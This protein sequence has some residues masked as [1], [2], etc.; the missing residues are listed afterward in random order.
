[1]CVCGGGGGLREGEGRGGRC[2]GIWY[3][4]MKI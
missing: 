4:T 2:L 3:E 1:M